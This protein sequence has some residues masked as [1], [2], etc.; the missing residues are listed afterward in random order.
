MTDKRSFNA[1]FAFAHLLA[2]QEFRDFLTENKLRGLPVVA[3]YDG[4][5]HFQLKVDQTFD[6]HETDEILIVSVDDTQ[7]FGLRIEKRRKD[8]KA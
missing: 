1:G 8:E 3:T 7:P 5:V 4:D 2:K 6:V